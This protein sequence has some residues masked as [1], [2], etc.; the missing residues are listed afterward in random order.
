MKFGKAVV[1]SRIVILVVA[2]A[3]MVPSL[4]GMIFT[5]VN[6]DMLNYLPDNLETV[7]GQEYLLDEF[8]KG[9]FSFL[10]VDNMEPKDVAE[11]EDKI[12]KVDHVDTVLW[13][14][15]IAD[16]SV[17]IDVLPEKVY[18]A[19]NSGNSTLMAIFFPRLISYPSSASRRRKSSQS[20]GFLRIRSSRTDR[21]SLRTVCRLGYSVLLVRSAYGFLSI[22]E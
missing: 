1:K 20:F 21:I 6:Y 17:P 19:F 11:L 4:F 10:I 22:M 15:D 13:Y 16:L 7:K 5:R 3:L 2:I 18:N 12:R 14:S 8:G 9:A